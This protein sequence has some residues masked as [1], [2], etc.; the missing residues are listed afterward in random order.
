MITKMKKYTFL[1]YHKQYHDFLEKLR[2]VGVLHVVERQKGTSENDELRAKMQ[3]AAKIKKTIA[4]A[5]PLLLPDLTP[6]EMSDYNG[7]NLLTEWDEMQATKNRLQQTIDN[8]KKEAERM[9]VWGDFDAN[10]LAKLAENGYVLQYFICPENK[11]N[12]SWE[13]EFNAFVINTIKQKTYFVTIN[14][15]SVNIDAETVALND[16]NSQQLLTDAEAQRMLLVA[17]ETKM[18]AWVV[19]NL[20]NLKDFQLQIESNIDFRKTELSATVEAEETVMLLEGFCPQDTENELNTMLEK[21]GIYYQISKPEVGEDIPIKLKNNFFAKLFEPITNLYS[22][23]NYGEL[24]PTAFFAPFFM[25][26]FGLC[27]GDGGYG[28]LILIAAT[29]AKYKL[30]KFKKFAILG[31]FLGGATILVGLLTGV[32]FGIMLETVA[33]P[34]LADVKKYFLT[35]NNYSAKIGG[36]DP[37]MVVAI[38]VGVFQILFAMGF[39]VVKITIQHGFKHAASTLAWLVGLIDGLVLLA[40]MMGAEMPQMVLYGLYGIAVLCGLVILFYNSPG[41][42]PFVN[43]GAG[44][45]GTYNM[46]S[47]LLGDVLSYIRLFALG[48]AGGILGN[49][50]NMLAMDLTVE[51]SP[52]VRW[53]PML[54]ILLIGHALNFMLCIISS[55]VHPLRLTFVEFYKNADF[56]GGGKIYRPFKKQTKSE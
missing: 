38:G 48:L 28:L 35:S 56:E 20:A 23:P 43:L 53:L 2:D 18:L 29:I 45:W 30:P 11:F 49:V 15:E 32:F 52:F 47:G 26:F 33:W 22:L 39:K 50:F 34:W 14:R 55:I 1:V 36:Y 21:E 3:L 31:Q 6:H 12:S 19:D 40:P 5:T 46:V 37:M 27:L 9:A 7:A 10:K 54:L 13:T 25:L 4:E 16:H 44:L 24:D 17:H 42:N 8:T 51:M 41:K